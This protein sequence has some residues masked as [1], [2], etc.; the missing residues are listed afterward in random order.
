MANLLEILQFPSFNL[1]TDIFFTEID[2]KYH[3]QLKIYTFVTN[4]EWDYNILLNN[5][6]LNTIKYDD[7]FQNKKKLYLY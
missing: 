4:D 5:H 1:L 6:K 3:Y 7:N 2:E